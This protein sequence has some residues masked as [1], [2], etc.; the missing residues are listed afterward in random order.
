MS[1][2]NDDTM[3]VLAAGYSSVAAAVSDFDAV[4]SVYANSAS[5]AG[6][7]DAA[8]INPH[9]TDPSSRVIRE[10]PPSQQRRTGGAGVEGL[11]KRLAR[12]LAEGMA[13]TGGPA[14]GGGQVIPAAA[15]TDDG[16][17]TLNSDDLKKLGAV[18][19]NASAVLI[20][21]FPAVV[22]ERIATATNAADFHASRE[23]RASAEQLEAQIITAERKSI[24]D[25][26]R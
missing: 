19:K 14:G 16:T 5:A 9:D 11:A 17:D 22:S 2:S 8:V 18:Q 26:Q 21:I 24:A 10:T 25:A 20:G 13:L 15:G 12:Y 7:C 23:L 3:V 1:Q 4:S 6:S